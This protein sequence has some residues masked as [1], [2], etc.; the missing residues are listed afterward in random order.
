MKLL[1]FR[2]AVE[3]NPSFSPVAGILLV[4]TPVDFRNSV[5]YIV[6]CFSPVAGI[7]LVE[8][9]SLS[10]T[11]KHKYQCFSPVAGILLV[12]TTKSGKKNRAIV[13]WFQSRCRDSVS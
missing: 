7:L 5:D 1:L 9:L 2:E 8:T 3:C 13:L 11:S 6:L 12:E 4:E 10:T